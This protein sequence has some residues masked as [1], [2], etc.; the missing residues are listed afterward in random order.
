MRRRGP[1]KI[2]DF[3]GVIAA[4]PLHF[5]PYTLHLTPYT[6]PPILY[7]KKKKYETIIQRCFST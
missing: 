2:Y 7:T 1:H 6:L 3:W 4:P 5:T